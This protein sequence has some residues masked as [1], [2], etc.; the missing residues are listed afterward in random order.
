M[1]GSGLI[2]LEAGRSIRWDLIS[3]IIPAWNGG[4]S[5]M[6]NGGHVLV[7]ISCETQEEAIEKANQIRARVHEAGVR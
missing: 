7:R 1:S 6:V 5:V 2:Y 4:W 3:S